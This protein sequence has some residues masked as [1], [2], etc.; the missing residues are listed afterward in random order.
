MLFRFFFSFM[1]LICAQNNLQAQMPVIQFLDSGRQCSLRGLSVVSDDI[2]WASGSKGTVARS[3]NG[4]ASFEWITVAGYEDREFRDIQAFDS[5][6]AVIMAIASPGIILKTRDGGKSWY[7][8]FED[9]TSGMFLDAMDFDEAGINGLVAGDP[10]PNDSRIYFAMTQNQGESWHNVTGNSTMFKT[11]EGEAMF[12]SSGTNLAFPSAVVTGGKASRI[13]YNGIFTLP[14][15]QGTE[16]TGANSIAISPDGRN[17]VVVGGDFSNDKL[18][19]NNCVL[20]Q[21]KRR[22]VF[23]IP[24]TPPH[25]YRSCV[26]YTAKNDLVTC[27][28]SGTDISTDGGRNWQ[29]IS[30]ASFHVCDKARKGKVVFLAGTRGRIAKVVM[31]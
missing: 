7:K 15:M 17:A 30:T 4:G 19:T 23:G 8:V 10:L 21:L 31:P 12:A 22:P 6:K 18:N 25:G 9:T 5:N 29:N 27:G 28:S 16:S 13:F 14:I 11:V 24:S 20:I 2:I 26:I 1:I 3:T